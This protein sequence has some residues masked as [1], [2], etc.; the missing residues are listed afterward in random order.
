MSERRNRTL[1]DIV[2]SMMSFTDLSVSFR[3][4][5]LKTAVNILNR[6]PLKS[7]PK[8]PYEIWI[9][10]KSSLKYVKIWDCSAYVKRV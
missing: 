2:R 7:I 1:L 9:G 4:Y 6:V 10:R 8:T 5:A 3:G